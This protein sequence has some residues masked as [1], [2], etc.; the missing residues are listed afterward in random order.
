[1]EEICASLRIMHYM[2]SSRGAMA[3]RFTFARPAKARSSSHSVPLADAL[4]Y[5]TSTVTP[6]LQPL[7][8]PPPALIKARINRAI[9]QIILSSVLR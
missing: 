2:Y 5:H 7:N 8:I 9:D 1:M 4:S 3:S 6:A